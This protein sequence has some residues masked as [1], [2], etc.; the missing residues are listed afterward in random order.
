MA[1]SLPASS[2]QLQK[3]H[4]THHIAAATGQ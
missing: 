2:T 1:L 3:E 4:A